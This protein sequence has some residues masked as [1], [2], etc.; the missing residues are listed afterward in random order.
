MAFK[1]HIAGFMTN[2]I[3]GGIVII[4]MEHNK[5]AYADFFFQKIYHRDLTGETK[6]D[7][8]VWLEE[9]PTLSLDMPIEWETIDH[10]NRL[11]FKVVSG[12]F[13]KDGHL[14][15]IHHLTD[16]TEYMTLNRDVSKYMSF[17][18]KLSKFQTAILEKLQ[19]S[20]HELLPI[21]ADLF[22]IDKVM[23]KIKY[24]NSERIVTYN[25][26]TQAYSKE[27]ITDTLLGLLCKGTISDQDYA[28]YYTENEK[29]DRESISEETLLSVIRLYIEN[30]MMRE[31]LVYDSEHDR[32]TGMYN[33]RKYMLMLETEYNHLDSI[34]IFNFDVNDLK[35]MN[36]TYGHEAGDKLII[37][38]AD[39]IRKITGP[40]VHGYRI[41][42]D[43]FLV[44]ACNFTQLQIN[45]LK[46]SWE[47]ELD[48]LNT[49]DDNICCEIAVGMIYAE[50]G[51]KLQDLLNE[52]DLRMYQDK[53][54]KKNRKRDV[55][56]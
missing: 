39:S 19:G 40:D 34:A 52:A 48:R 24:E 29:M 14:Y 37:K 17:F 18:K 4:D 49:L 41:G 35:K 46:M 6:K 25:K 15:Q 28:L 47:Q 56:S 38:A 30:G 11:Y 31:K 13:E 22:K 20:Y 26:A 10:E 51:Y 55:C 54:Q 21:L 50:K 12:L 16:I 3:G 42:G 8:L 33:K 43:E 5:I 9:C 45:Q 53:E 32:L 2:D 27:P 23:L 7:I 1:K 36:D 44:V